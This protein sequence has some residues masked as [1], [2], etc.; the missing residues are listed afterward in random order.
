MTKELLY[1]PILKWKAAELT[2]IANIDDSHRESLL[3]LAEIV[4]PGVSAYIS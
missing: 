4:L 3:P 1:V 2:A